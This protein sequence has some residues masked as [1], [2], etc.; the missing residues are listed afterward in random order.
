[1]WDPLPLIAST[2]LSGSYGIPLAEM[3]IRREQANNVL[4]RVRRSNSFL[5]ELKKGNLER[6]CMEET[7]S[8]EEAREVFEDIDKTVRFRNPLFADG[9]QCET[10]PCQNEGKCRDG[11]GEYTCT[12]LEGFEG[13]NCE[14]CRF[15][16][17]IPCMLIFA[18]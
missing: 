1:R 13:K 2:S 11:L 16:C 14:L 17:L 6:E 7:C 12:C 15:L 4:A 5:E 9:D 10:S 8:Y 3:F 18:L